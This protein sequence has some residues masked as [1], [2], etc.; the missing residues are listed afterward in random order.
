MSLSDCVNCWDTPCRCGW[1]YREWSKQSRIQLASVC[2][3]VTANEI[4]TAL[5]D[6]ISDKHPCILIKGK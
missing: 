5:G 6:K 4:I 1:E 2:L 3:G